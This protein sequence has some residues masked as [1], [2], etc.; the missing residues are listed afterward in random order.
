MLKTTGGVLLG[1]LVGC[2]SNTPSTTTRDLGAP[3]TGH[4]IMANDK[5]NAPRDQEVQDSQ[6]DRG[7]AP[8]SQRDSTS[9][10][11][12]PNPNA[13]IFFVHLS[14]I[15]LGA[16][17][18]PEPALNLALSEILPTISP[19]ATFATGDLCENGNDLSNWQTY[20]KTVDAAGLSPL[21]Y[22]ETPG[23]HDCLLD[24]ALK[25]YLAHTLAGRNAHGTHGLYHVTVNG[26]RIR[27]VALNT[28]SAG[29]LVQD[30]TG[31]LKEDQVNQLILQIDADKQPVD[32]TL[33]L[34]H[35]PIVWANGLGLFHTDKN[36]RRL[37]AHTHAS[38]YLYGH[39]HLFVENWEK[40]TLMAM[41]PS[42]GRINNL[43]GLLIS[44]QGFSLFALDDGPVVKPVFIHGE[45]TSLTVEWPVVMI[46]RPAKAGANPWVTRLT[47]GTFN[48]LL[49]AGV[50]APNTIHAVRYRIDSGPWKTMSPKTGY[51]EAMFNTPNKSS[52]TIEVEGESSG[53]I[54][55][56][57]L[58]IPL[59]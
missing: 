16:G 45:A 41:A 55:S 21:T 5:A 10:D 48:N 38:A 15:H 58:T 3:D 33:V 53:A 47:R 50:F 49:H 19:A 18:R 17:S 56:D 1:T 20:R 42:L 8:D 30:S 13:P 12:S 4:D 29:N 27:I 57:K 54:G 37:L 46:T 6:R 9:P 14:D 52:C 31:Y 39:L 7:A 59:A 44:L 26:R 51:Y 40:Q 36:L 43:Q 25:N 23:N 22:I 32:T 2:S 11:S 28:V 35:H 24:S 34:G